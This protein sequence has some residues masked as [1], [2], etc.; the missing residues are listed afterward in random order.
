MPN[1][2]FDVFISYSSKDQKIADELVAYLEQQGIRCWIA[3]RDIPVGHPSYAQPIVDAISQTKVFVLIFSAQ[4]NQSQDVLQETD[5]AKN[6]KKVIIPFRI[7]STSLDGSAFEY[8]L[9]IRQWI[10]AASAPREYFPNLE[11]AIRRQIGST[12]NAFCVPAQPPMG[13]APLENLK[14]RAQAGDPAAQLKLGLCYANGEGV[15]KNFAIA[16][17]WV[18]KAAEQG[19]TEAQNQLGLFYDKEAPVEAAKWF[20]KAAE[21][22][23][24]RAQWNLGLCYENGDGVRKNSATALKWFRKAAE[25][26]DSD[27]QRKLNEMEQQRTYC[28]QIK[29]EQQNDPEI[30][31][32]LGDL[33]SG[34]PAKKRLIFVV[35]AFL[36][37]GLGVHNFY[38]G[39]I[40][41]GIIQLVVFLLFFELYGGVIT[42]IWAII[43]AC[44]VTCDARGIPF[45]KIS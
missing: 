20:R 36:A 7:D 3:S 19:H 16:V 4:S 13:K 45:Q 39:Y 22:G 32:Q 12:P 2:D 43:E 30:Q 24:P 40:K 31:N 38:A 5:L 34:K 8:Y 10:A 9:T 14:R 37:G 35:L 11:E 6:K 26:G 15:R 21:Q 1:N 18:R 27:A 29:A 25:H 41:R 28:T 33:C 23:L 44:T 42:S 17:K